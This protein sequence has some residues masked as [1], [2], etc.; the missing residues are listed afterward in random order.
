MRDPPVRVRNMN[1]KT[2]SV[3]WFVD[4]WQRYGMRKRPE[5]QTVVPESPG[6]ASRERDEGGEG[7]EEGIP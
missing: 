2:V 1:S 6:P 5:V 3:V 4:I 7:G